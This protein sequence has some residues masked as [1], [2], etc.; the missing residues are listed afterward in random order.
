MPL[1][2]MIHG[3]L[4]ICTS[5]LYC[6]TPSADKFQRPSKKGAY[7]SADADGGGGYVY[8]NMLYITLYTYRRPGDTVAGRADTQNNRHLS[9]LTQKEREAASAHNA[10]H[11]RA[12]R[13]QGAQGPPRVRARVYERGRPCAPNPAPSSL[14]PATPRRKSPYAP[15]ST[16]MPARTRARRTRLRRRPRGCDARAGG[17]RTRRRSRRREACAARRPRTRAAR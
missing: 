16:S 14:D 6:T 8:S 11:E 4:G 10:E 7:A 5:T 15:A 17:R 3:G 9:S 2:V 12:L 13:T 1:E